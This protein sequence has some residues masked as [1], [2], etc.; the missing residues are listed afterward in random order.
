VIRRPTTAAPSNAVAAVAALVALTHPVPSLATVGV[1][2]GF[3]VLLVGGLPALDR[4][5]LLAAML[6]C[7]QFA[8][9]LHNDWCDRDLDAAAK[10]WRAIPAGVVSAGTVRV[11]AWALAVASLGAA[12]PLGATEVA[13][14]GLGI[15]AGFAY[16]AYLKATPLSWLPFAVAFPLLPLFGAAAFGAWPA[17]WWSLF[18]VGL[19]CV[20]AI[21]LADS[22]PDL[23]S[24]A[25]AGAGGLAHRL[26]AAAARRVSLLALGVA[27]VLGWSGAFLLSSSPAGAGAAV[28]SA[29][30]VLAVA[31]PAAR[32]FAVTIGAAA[33]ALGWVAGL[34][35]ATP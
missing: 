27:A 1:A 10:P 13:L 34:A 4:L 26:G 31:V 5:A 8:I 29:A 15:A 6:V 16:N 14:D 7:Q 17:A 11:A 25:A 22:L 33:V 23:A 28:A 19:P 2:V 9:S 24:D 32:R 30:L 21:H 3:T 35:R 18:V 12:L 20:V